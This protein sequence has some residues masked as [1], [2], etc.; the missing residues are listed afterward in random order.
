MTYKTEL[1]NNALA[2]LFT[3]DQP[4]VAQAVIN[5]YTVCANFMYGHE[6]MRPLTTADALPQI[7]K[8]APALPECMNNVSRFWSVD[9]ENG[10]PLS[11]YYSLEAAIESI[12]DESW[13]LE[14]SLM[15]YTGK[16]EVDLVITCPSGKSSGSITFKDKADAE[17]FI[18]TITEGGW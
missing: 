8:G 6:D 5:G 12:E 16:T 17:A 13:K 2:Q 11:D 18:K 14:F 9:K 15:E 10:S 7:M 1:L 3:G 4:K